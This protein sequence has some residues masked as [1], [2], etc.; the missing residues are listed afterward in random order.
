MHPV[1][2]AKLRVSAL[3]FGGERRTQRQVV[4]TLWLALISVAAVNPRG[5]A[6]LQGLGVIDKTYSQG[7]FSCWPF[8]EWVTASRRGNPADAET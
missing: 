7:T 1:S 8:S 6:T 3:N 5:F 2:S 4:A